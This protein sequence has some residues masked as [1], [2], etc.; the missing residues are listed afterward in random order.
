MFVS[1]SNVGNLCVSG[2]RYEVGS[3]QQ[4]IDEVNDLYLCAC[5]ITQPCK[6]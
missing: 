5:A 4:Q 3:R 1:C 2:S 6:D